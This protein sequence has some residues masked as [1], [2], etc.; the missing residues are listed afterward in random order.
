MD[1]LYKA[2]KDRDDVRFFIIYTTEPHAR[3]P[4]P[5]WNFINI[6]QSK[7]YEQRR[8]YAQACRREHGIDMP[9]LIDTMDGKVQSAYGGLPN[10]AVIIDKD[11][12]IAAT[13]KWI[14]PLF[15]ELSLREIVPDP[16]QV[17][18]VETMGECENCHQEQVKK[19]AAE[20][21]ITDCSACHAHF[22]MN[23]PTRTN[24]RA[25]NHIENPDKPFKNEMNCAVLCHNMKFVP[26]EKKIEGLEFSHTRHFERGAGCIHCH[27]TKGHAFHDISSDVCLGCHVQKGNIE[28][29]PDNLIGWKK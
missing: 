5:G 9:I 12:N 3:Q 15:V 20:H 7:T 18:H 17:N 28:V 13:K 4:I 14:D 2:Y 19:I 1:E 25:K 24:R 29:K 11:G 16:P 27:G 6:G 8:E 10:S 26:Q 23:I 22:Y 21:P